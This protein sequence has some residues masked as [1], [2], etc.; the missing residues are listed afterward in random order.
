MEVFV[1]ISRSSI[2]L[3]AFFCAFPQSTQSSN[4]GAISQKIGTFITDLVVPMVVTT[5]LTIGII[6]A[7]AYIG[8]KI[9]PYLCSV[10]KLHKAGSIT[11]KFDSIA[12]QESIKEEIEDIVDYLRDRKKYDAMG[13]KVPKGLMM[14]G[15]P[16]TGKTSLA[17]AMAGEVSCSFIV[18]TGS[19]L[20][21]TGVNG[22][23]SIKALFRKARFHAPSIVFIDEI[24]SMCADAQ[25]QLL[26]EMDGFERRKELVIV[27]GATNFIQNLHPGLIRAGRFDRVIKV[28]LPSLADRKKILALY[29]HKVK[30]AEAIDLDTLADL[31]TGFSCADLAKLINEASILAL[32]AQKE[33]IDQNDLEE[34]LDKLSQGKPVKDAPITAEEKRIIA[35]HEAGHALVNILLRADCDPL[36]K[37]TII[38]RGTSEGFTAMVPRSGIGNTK[39]Q[40]LGTIAV[41]CGGR[42]AEM[43]VF[44]ILSTGAQSD[45]IKA[46]KL[47][48]DMVCEYAMSE[49]IGQS[50][51]LSQLSITGATELKK[52]A[53]IHAILK[54]AYD[55]AYTLLKEHR[56]KLDL[57]VQELLEKETL[58]GRQVYEL[59]GIEYPKIKKVGLV[60]ATV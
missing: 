53:A 51:V 17:R 7:A 44:N 43:L 50:I 56:D 15:P 16:G 6:S 54:N 47:A 4:N 39:E 25:Q 58:S 35:Y 21:R 2:I 24:D 46:T 13:T 59:L 30:M 1:N 38:A 36:H 48:K 14:Y 20:D 26:T 9:Y 40:F 10:G 28:D 23:E 5:T 55:K 60:I 22:A 3:V 33:M 32:H 34:A 18:I 12:G 52:E 27:V 41:A 8:K 11:E 42:A 49:D 29:A 45:L 37:V 57:I 19:E 31:T